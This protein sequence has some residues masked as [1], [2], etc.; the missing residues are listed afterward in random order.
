MAKA[1]RKFMD[2]CPQI[3]VQHMA[4]YPAGRALEAWQDDSGATWLRSLIVDEDAKALVRRG[5]LKAYS[6]GIADPQTLKSDRCKRHEIVGGRLSEV[7]IVAS[8]ANARAGI[9]VCKMRGGK[10]VYVGKAYGLT[11]AEKKAAKEIRKSMQRPPV[12]H[13][14]ADLW[15]T[16]R[17]TDDPFEREAAREALTARGAL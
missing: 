13:V 6:V 17:T 2:I 12:D 4:N 3:R 9:T 5:T 15:L 1:V 14:Y 11:K 8:P 7:S 10:A 16:W